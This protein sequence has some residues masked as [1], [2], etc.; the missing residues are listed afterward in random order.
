MRSFPLLTDR[1]LL[2]LLLLLL[3][4]LLLPQSCLSDGLGDVLHAANGEET[5]GQEPSVTNV[6]WANFDGEEGSSRSKMKHV[7]RRAPH[8]VLGAGGAGSAGFPLPD[9][10]SGRLSVNILALALRF[11]GI[12]LNIVLCA[13]A[14]Y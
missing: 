10:L 14:L 9:F 5:A 7:S 11:S 12:H 2:L 6:P 3:F 8:R 4:L 1:L 13:L